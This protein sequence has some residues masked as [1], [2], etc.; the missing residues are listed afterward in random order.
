VSL[1]YTLAL[2]MVLAVF[3]VVFVKTE[4]GLHLIVLS[5][6][7]S[8]EFG[9]GAATLAE[10][11]QVVLRFEDFLLGATALAW[12]AKTAV[13][14]ELGLVAT[15]PL[16][17][18]IFYYIAA[19]ALATLVGYLTG[20]VRGL[21]GFFYVLKYVEYFFVYY[22]VVNNLRDRAQAWRLVTTAFLTA[23]IVSVVGI[24]QVPSG[25]RVSA[26]FEGES[27]EPNTF[28]G[29]LLFMMALAAGVA[30]ET[31][32]L[33]TRW[34]LVVLGGLMLIPFAFTLSRSSYLGL[35]PAALV[36]VFLSTRRRFTI[37]LLV[38]A[39]ACSPLAFLALPQVVVKR[40]L[41]TFETESTSPTVRIGRVGF[42]PSTSARLVSFNQ[43]IEGWTKRPIL[44]H[45]VTGFGFLDAQ[46]P[47]V[48][49][50]TGV[51]GL[52]A[53]LFLLWA[54][55]RS[56]MLAL[57]RVRDPDDRGLGIGFVAGFVGLCT[58][59]IG[60][61][62]F[63]IVRIMEPF[64]LF[65]GIITMLPLLERAESAPAPAPAPRPLVLRG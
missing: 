11:R 17:R 18:P 34:R 20:T 43:A 57:R 27:G 65:V 52:G 49:V 55:F 51:V 29:Y 56:G 58:H 63:I 62:T 22:I 23:A 35:V 33:L 47:R 19:T 39:L 30:L 14:K 16:N 21:G 6:L 32:H 44:G 4:F 61:N 36:L 2:V 28:G 31:P 46:Y 38:L 9:G 42:D 3:L 1:E 41:Y 12:L 64:W 45:G 24:A 50:E 54:V 7:L 15:T 60:A 48:L 53:F 5:M 25:E 40:V 37:G 26:P 10:R 59:A 13:N 8:P